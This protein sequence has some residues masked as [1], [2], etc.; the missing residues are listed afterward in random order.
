MSAFLGPIHYWLHGKIMIQNDIVEEILKL[1]KEEYNIDYRQDI[2]NEYGI[3]E[4][5]PL[6]Q[7]IDESNIHGWL[8]ERIHIVEKRLAYVVTN[9]IKDQGQSLEEIKKIYRQTGL[10]ESEKS[11]LSRQ[12]TVSQIYKAAVNDSLID[13]MPCDHVNAVKSQDDYEITWKRTQCV[14]KEYWDD[15]GGDV[16]I[17]YDL[18]DEYIE[19]F[20]ENFDVTYKKLDDSTYKISK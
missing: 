14:H 11:K 15:L 20:L 17:Y 8:Q 16:S 1:A 5:E 19:G 9:L 10:A 2:D 13:G 6:E 4:L 12:A 3:I 18:R 7:V